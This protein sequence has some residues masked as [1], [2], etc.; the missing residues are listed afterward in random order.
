MYSLLLEMQE[1]ESGPS[2]TV[3]IVLPVVLAD[4]LRD[5][6][7]SRNVGLSTLVRMMLSASMEQQERTPA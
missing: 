6:A 2:V 5:Y 3:Q 7:K 4:R 1:T